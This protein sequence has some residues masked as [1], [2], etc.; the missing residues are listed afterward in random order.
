MAFGGSDAGLNSRSCRSATVSPVIAPSS[1]RTPIASLHAQLRG[2]V[3]RRER[4]R[5]RQHERRPTPAICRNQNICRGAS[6]PHCHRSDRDSAG[7]RRWSGVRAAMCSPSRRHQPAAKSGDQRSGASGQP[8][9]RHHTRLKPRRRRRRRSRMYRPSRSFR[10]FC[11]MHPGDRH[12]RST[13][14][15]R[16]DRQRGEL[17]SQRHVLNS[18]TNG[19]TRRPIKPLRRRS[20][21]IATRQMHSSPAIHDR[22]MVDRRRRDRNR[23]ARNGRR[24]GRRRR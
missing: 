19:C 1:S 22:L 5:D 18:R 6:P 21:C 17:K 4:D 16:C 20:P 2:G 13:A 15:P 10:C 3:M 8:R 9:E 24:R 23:Q 11:W 12:D 7:R 14:P